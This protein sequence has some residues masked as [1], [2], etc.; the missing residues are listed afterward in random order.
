MEQKS[1]SK[2]GG[3][4]LKEPEKTINSQK[5]DDKEKKDGRTTQK[6]KTDS[7]NL[8]S[9]KKEEQNVEK[10]VEPVSEKKNDSKNPTTIKQES[11]T[12]ENDKDKEKIN[13]NHPI[14]SMDMKKNNENKENDK[15]QEKNTI[16]APILEQKIEN[17]PLDKKITNVSQDNIEPKE[18]NLENFDS[19]L[20]ES[21]ENNS[22][23]NNQPKD[24]EK[25]KKPR[26]SD[27]FTQYLEN[28]GVSMAFQIIFAEILSKNVP[29]D[30]VY[31]YTAMRLR[32]IG[33][34]L[35]KIQQVNQ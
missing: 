31:G 7:K 12:K 17:N 11:P 14:K 15:S 25:D 26:P 19:S 16:S 1:N 34:E 3:S 21:V 35:N 23:I 6:K 20:V 2:A 10:K 5:I 9:E 8:N 4:G 18:L 30:S 22:I 32:Q 33:A 13:E 27:Q 28:T 24:K 29:S